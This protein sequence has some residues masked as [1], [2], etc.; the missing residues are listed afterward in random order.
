MRSKEACRKLGWSGEPQ[1][2]HGCYVSADA[3]YLYITES[4]GINDTQIRVPIKQ[5]RKLADLIQK[6][7][8]L[9]S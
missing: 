6:H 1:G 2:Y 8:T 4:E 5:A 7:A 3:S 9:N